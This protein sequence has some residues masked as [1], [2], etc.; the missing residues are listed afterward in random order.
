MQKAYPDAAKL[1][2][3]GHWTKT[4]GAAVVKSSKAGFSNNWESK[5]QSDSVRKHRGMGGFTTY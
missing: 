4:V 1:M 2:E 5:S 3:A